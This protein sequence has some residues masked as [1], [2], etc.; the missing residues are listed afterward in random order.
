M[1]VD[2]TI[3]GKCYWRL[4]VDLEGRKVVDTDGEEALWFFALHASKSNSQCLLL[5]V[6]H[7]DTCATVSEI[8]A[9]I[10]QHIT[11]FSTA[12]TTAPLHRPANLDIAVPD[13]DVCKGARC[14]PCESRCHKATAQQ[15]AR[16][17]AV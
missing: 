11:I 16:G 8:K 17:R 13:E 1:E 3:T 4:F 10:P 5:Q 7:T 9:T 2:E 15:Q 14:R 6:A 12:P